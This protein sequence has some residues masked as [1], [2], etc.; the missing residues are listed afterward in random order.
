[1]GCGT[2]IDVIYGEN[3][4]RVSDLDVKEGG[5]HERFFTGLAIN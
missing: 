3:S 5:Q 4:I 2:R 1:M